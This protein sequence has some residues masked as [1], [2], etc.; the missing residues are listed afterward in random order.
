MPMPMLP[1]FRTVKIFVEV[2]IVKSAFEAARVV[3]AILRS[4]EI[5]EV[6]VTLKS[7]VDETQVKLESDAKVE[8]VV[9]KVI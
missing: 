9:Q 6:P 4:P 7:W 8:L 2:A 5:V 1:V 3:V